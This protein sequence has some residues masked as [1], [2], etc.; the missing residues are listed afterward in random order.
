MTPRLNSKARSGNMPV[1]QALLANSR[2]RHQL[3][4]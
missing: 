2:Y 1:L 4:R 3:E